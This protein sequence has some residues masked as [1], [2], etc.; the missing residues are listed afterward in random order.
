MGNS[1]DGAQ[2][3]L[4]AT[5]GILLASLGA[6]APT[7][8]TTFDTLYTFPGPADDEYI[9]AGVTLDSSGN[10]YGT[11]TTQ[12]GS[13]GDGCTS[14]C[15][16]VFMLKPPGKKGGS[17]TEKTI[18]SFSGADGSYPGTGGLLLQSGNLYGTTYYGGATNFGLVFELSPPAQGQS[19]WRIRTLHSFKGAG[20]GANPNAGV[21][22]D[23]KGNLYGVA[24]A[25]GKA[26][27]GTVYELVPPAP[28]KTG[29]TEKTLHSFA[30]GSDGSFP[31]AGLVLDGN[32]NLY[33][34][35][36]AGG[37]SDACN[38]NYSP[39]AGCGTVFMLS[40]PAD[41]HQRWT[42][43][44]L[45][46]FQSG[47]DGRNPIGGLIFDISG[48]LIG[49][50]QFGGN[51]AQ[52]CDGDYGPGCGL[53]FKF[54]PPSR[55]GAEW[56]ETILHVFTFANDGA[57][58]N[59]GLIADGDTGSFYGTGPHGGPGG[60]GTAYEM[61]ETGDVTLLNDFAGGASG[62]TPFGGLAISGNGTLYG[63]T[64]ESTPGSFGTVY[65]ISP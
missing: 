26:N 41:G 38:D 65:S 15:G 42:E 63:T 3:R 60:F 16:S 8:A 35:T 53:A 11:T 5:L 24:F 4:T 59:S 64:F 52:G 22:M 12:L 33:G 37:G 9:V 31:Y 57:F 20:D 39:G 45:H 13:M 40:P 34:T 25:G 6:S 56:T 49:T 32:G 21:T 30:G 23:P 54:Q 47:D 17:W 28:G 43:T 46:S 61:F 50:T 58:P 48:N 51:G 10:V 44:I 29:W 36:E 2:F 55:R 14:Q 1:F 18:H 62:S 7:S 27:L 19:R